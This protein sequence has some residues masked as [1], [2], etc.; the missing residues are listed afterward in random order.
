MNFS[1]APK[2]LECRFYRGDAS[3]LMRVAGKCTKTDSVVDSLVLEE[4]ENWSNSL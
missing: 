1:M 4:T 3:V 2:S